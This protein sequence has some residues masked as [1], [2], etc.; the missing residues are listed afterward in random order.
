MSTYLQSYRDGT[1]SVA[2]GSTAVTGALTL[3][4]ANVQPGDRIVIGATE[5][6]V[7]SVTSNTALV[8]VSAWG[9]ATATGANYV[10]NRWS[11]GWSAAGTTA[12]LLALYESNRPSFIPVTGTPSN[13]VGADGNIAVDWTAGLIYQKAAGVWGN[14]VAFRLRPRGAY[15]GATAYL[16]GDV[17]TDQSASWVNLTGSTGAAPP[18]LPT[19]TNANW[20]LLAKSGELTRSGA[21]TV[22]RPASWISNTQLGDIGYTP[23][24]V[25]AANRTYYVRPDGNNANTGLA[26]TA[27][28]AFLTIQRAVDVAASID[29]SIYTVTIQ[30]A[31]GTYAENVVLKRLTSGAVIIQGNSAAYADVVVACSGAYAGCIFSSGVTGY[32]IRYMTLTGPSSGTTY[33]LRVIGGELIFGGIVFGAGNYY[34]VYAEGAA[35]S[36]TAACTQS[37]ACSTLIYATSLSRV[38]M[39]GM[40]WVFSGNPSIGTFVYVDQSRVNAWSM[41]FTGTAV[42]TKYSVA[43]NGALVAYGGAASFP[44]GTAGTT[45]SGGQVL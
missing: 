16:I 5:A 25:L 32:T 13:A 19:E 14:G 35:V 21:V 12:L 11:K 24:E 40:T 45:A 27:G 18:A 2:N 3:W 34:S 43:A 29:I 20:S 42:G 23:R 1:A 39:A 28:G 31:A 22:G 26:N 41:T 38:A 33:G 37:G 7:A 4:A 30:L 9:G 6:E 10:I 8:L 36:Q 44:G 17:V 15:G